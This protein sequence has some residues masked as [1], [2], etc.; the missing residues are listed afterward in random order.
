M[1]RE[2][3][4]KT[5]SVFKSE[6]F[7]YKMSIFGVKRKEFCYAGAWSF[8]LNLA[9]GVASQC[10][11]SFFRQNI[12][13]NLSKPIKFKPIGN[14]CKL[15]HCYNGHAFLVL[16]LIPELKA[17]TYG[18]IRNRKCLDGTEWLRPEMKAFMNT[19]LFDSNKEYSSFGKFCANTEIKLKE[20]CSNIGRLKHIISKIAR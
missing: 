11:C 2:D 19:K 7:D 14:N 6:F 16:G 15:E 3:Y 18:E 13:E 17:P 10:Y 8:Y 20:M 4:K 9:T 12:F 5:W 1:N